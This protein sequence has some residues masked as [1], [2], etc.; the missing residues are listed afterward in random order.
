MYAKVKKTQISQT[1]IWTLKKI[2]ERGRLHIKAFADFIHRGICS[3]SDDAGQLRI[4]L[5]ETK[6][7]MSEPQK[8]H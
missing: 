2:I 4:L 1:E 8:S 3:V 5:R 6:D 7:Y